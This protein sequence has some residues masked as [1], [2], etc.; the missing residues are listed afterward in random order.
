M[1]R[2]PKPHRH[3][4][5]FYAPAQRQHRVFDVFLLVK[6]ICAIAQL[7]LHNKFSVISTT[8]WR[9]LQRGRQ[10]ATAGIWRNDE[11]GVRPRGSESIEGGCDAQRMDKFNRSGTSLEDQR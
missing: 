3:L 7:F 8:V 1:L 4:H 10:P 9:R 2:A 11:G 6:A 5:G